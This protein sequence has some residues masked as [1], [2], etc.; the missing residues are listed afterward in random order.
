MDSDEVLDKLFEGK[1]TFSEAAG[2]L[3]IS[4][5]EII[6]LFNKHEWIPSPEQLDLLM[7]AERESINYIRKISRSRTYSER[8]THPPEQLGE[9]IYVQPACMPDITITSNGTTSRS[10]FRPFRKLK[11]HGSQS[12]PQSESWSVKFEG[13][14]QWNH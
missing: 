11:P 14:G 9:G 1:L 10:P 3:G 8:L 5:D 12:Q 13:A 2:T 6:S 7:E 4:E